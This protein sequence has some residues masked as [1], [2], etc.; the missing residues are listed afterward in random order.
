[1]TE[2]LAISASSYDVFQQC[3]RMYYWKHVV[4]LSPT[5]TGG[6]RRFGSLYHA[7][8]EAWW[9]ESDGGVVPWKDRDLSLVMALRAIHDAAKRLEV[10]DVFEIAL[11]EALMTAYHV[12]YFD[13]DF[14][15]P[16]DMARSV[17]VD[18]E[19]PLVDE[20]GREVRGWVLRGKKD[21]IKRFPDKRTRPVEHKS[22]TYEISGTSDYWTQLRVNVQV[23]IYIDVSR[24]LG[25]SDVSEALYDVSRRPL[26]RPGLATPEEKRKYTKGKGCKHCGGRAGGKLGVAPGTGRIMVRTKVDGDGHLLPSPVDVET[27]C[28]SCDGTGWNEAPRLHEKQRLT[29]ESTLDFKSRVA[30]DI[31]DDPNEY[32]RMGTVTRSA[33]QIA[34]ARQDLVVTT[35]LIEALL[36]LARQAGDAYS[37]AARRVWPRNSAACTNVYG[38]RCDYLDVCSGAVEPFESP[39]YRIRGKGK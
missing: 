36:T 7:G 25:T 3:A 38:R 26:L 32:F 5:K 12:R 31:A 35:G 39:L 34:E 15:S 14:E 11:A 1:M 18:F 2:Q 4:R 27:S 30:S 16:P 29:D 22:T 8:L 10:L 33:D 9:H 13:L 28:T 17:E 21:S 19:L 23:S 6:A 24:R 20:R 37:P